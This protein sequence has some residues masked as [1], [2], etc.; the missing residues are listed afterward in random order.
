MWYKWLMPVAVTREGLFRCQAL[1]V[2]AYLREGDKSPVD[3]IRKLVDY[4]TPLNDGDL[5]MAQWA[6]ERI[7]QAY[8]N[9]AADP[10][11]PWTLLPQF[12]STEMRDQIP[13]NQLDL[14]PPAATLA[15]LDE[16]L[17]G[18]MVAF[19]T[20]ADAAELPVLCGE[21][22]GSR[23]RTAKSDRLLLGVAVG[24]AAA[25]TALGVTVVVKAT[26]SGSRRSSR[27]PSRTRRS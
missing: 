1:R 19:K 8:P 23:A 25:V 12:I 4:T 18:L 11:Y 17:E 9:A 21:A 16:H 14:W 27:K 13:W 20:I 6:V 7:Y 22:A 2:Q 5:A 26:P 3:E 15:L 24:L 10:S